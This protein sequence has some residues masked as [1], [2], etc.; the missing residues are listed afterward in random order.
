[1]AFIYQMGGSC[2]IATK[3]GKVTGVTL[4]SNDVGWGA[5]VTLKWDEAQDGIA[6]PVRKY[7]IYKNGVMI[8]YSDTC[9]A[10]VFAPEEN[11]SVTYAVKAIGRINGFD[12]DL[13]DQ[14]E[15][16]AN[17][18]DPTPPSFLSFGDGSEAACGAIVTLSW[19]GAS[20]GENNEI[21]R[22]K[23]YRGD[24]LVATT[25]KT[26]IQ[27]SAP[28]EKGTYD[29]FVVSCGYYT[30]SQKSDGITL[31][32]GDTYED[33]YILS[34]TDITIPLWSRRTDVTCIAAGGGGA[35]GGYG[36]TNHQKAYPAGGGAGGTGEIKHLFGAG[37][38]PGSTV[39]VTVGKGGPI[40][41]GSNDQPNDTE[42]G[43]ESKF[44]EWLT[45][46]GGCQGRYGDG[47]PL[48]DTSGANGG[49]GGKGG[50]GG[51]GGGSGWGRYSHC[52]G[53][54]GADG[55]SLLDWTN[56]DIKDWYVFRD[57]ATGRRLGQAGRG[58][59][60]NSLYAFSTRAAIGLTQKE[61]P[62]VMYGSGGRGGDQHKSGP[63]T[64]PEAGTNGLVAVRFWRYNG[65]TIK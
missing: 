2:A 60:G 28:K 43:G 9:E 7:A 49:R 3:C 24:S 6:N 55:D 65:T 1:M 50:I 22:Y 42:N 10:T 57:P 19:S 39:S 37:V 33:V 18:T 21:G 32:I 63:V 17:V 44:G 52:V 53:Y 62:G 11:G 27:M 23:I 5:S 14:V 40:Y 58:G 38:T 54:D 8:G 20:G 46:R 26:S 13:S 45:A 30:E 25:E 64:T 56:W 36:Y 35:R 4:G 16:R 48:N 29:Y 34:S 61:A 31:T 59:D 15:L 41:E 12:G 51:N 47:E